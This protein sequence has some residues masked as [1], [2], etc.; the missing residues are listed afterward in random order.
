MQA[1]PSEPL[2]PAFAHLPWPPRCLQTDVQTQLV[3]AGLSDV[4]HL[5]EESAALKA[6]AAERDAAIRAAT[7]QHDAAVRFLNQRL[8]R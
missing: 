7:S 1:Q 5:D 2:L 8:Q 4:R 6:A 3:R